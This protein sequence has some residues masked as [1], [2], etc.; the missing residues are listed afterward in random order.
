MARGR[1][2]RHRPAT[3]SHHPFQVRDDLSIASDPASLDLPEPIKARLP[4]PFRDPVADL[5][6]IED[7]RTWYPEAFRPPV[8]PRRNAR[9]IWSSPA[10]SPSRRPV[11]ARWGRV[12]P[13]RRVTAPTSSFRF[14]FKNPRYVMVC[15]RRHQRR[16]VLFAKGRTGRTRRSRRWTQ[17]SSVYCR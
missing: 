10:R 17:Q 8:T 14:R 5:L 16:E 15:V 4:N 7:R 13:G 9:V 6:S 2:N 1:P 11:F 12:S 3:P